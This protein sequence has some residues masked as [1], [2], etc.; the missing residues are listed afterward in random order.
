MSEEFYVRC[1]RLILDLVRM[2]NRGDLSHKTLPLYDSL[3]DKLFKA[4]LSC[5][6]ILESAQFSA[7]YLRTAQLIRKAIETGSQ[8]TNF[9]HGYGGILTQVPQKQKPSSPSNGWPFQLSISSLL[10]T[11]S[12]QSISPSLSGLHYRVYLV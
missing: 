3:G 11:I 8:T 4:Q 10:Y 7:N 1:P 5:I 2:W 6:R 9:V 12:V